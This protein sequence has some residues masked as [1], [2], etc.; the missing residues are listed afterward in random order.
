MADA[1]GTHSA[2]SEQP[3]LLP[4]AA[5]VV[6]WLMEAAVPIEHTGFF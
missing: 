1:N 6:A 2:T 5:E 4:R 3:E